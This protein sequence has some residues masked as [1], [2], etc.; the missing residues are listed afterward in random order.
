MNT[1]LVIFH[2]Y[3]IQLMVG[4]FN[5]PYTITALDGF[6]SSVITCTP[7]KLPG[8]ISEATKKWYEEEGEMKVDTKKYLVPVS[9]SRL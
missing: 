6:R 5:A 3:K 2:V 1:Y 8:A 4:H 7:E 9:V